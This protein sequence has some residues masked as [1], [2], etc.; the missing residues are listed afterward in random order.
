MNWS[1]LV[2]VYPNDNPEKVEVFEDIEK[3]AI[4]LDFKNEQLAEH[5]LFPNYELLIVPKVIL[6]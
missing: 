6:N 1:Y 3:A 2:I 5:D 4:Y